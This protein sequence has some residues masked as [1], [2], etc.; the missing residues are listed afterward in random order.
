VL[1]PEIKAFIDRHAER[2]ADEIA[3][4][5]PKYPDLPIPFIAR[6]VAGRRRIKEKL[7][8]WY[9][10]PDTV[11]PAT[12][13]LEQCSSEAAACYRASLASGRTAADLTGGFGVDAKFLA[14]RFERLFYCEKEREL[15]GLADAN[16][17][18]FGLGGKVECLAM[19]GLK[20]I[21]EYEGK[22]DLV[23]LDPARRDARQ[24]KV[25][26]LSEGEPDPLAVWEKLLERA[27]RVILKAS[28]G[29]DVD[30]ALRELS[31]VEEIHVVSVEGECKELLIVAS[32]LAVGEAKIVCANVTAVGRQER[33]EFLRSEEKEMEGNYALY[34][35][36]LYEP[37]ASIMKAGAFKTFG[38]KVG[39]PLLN[40]R[41]RFYTSKEFVEDFPGRV[42]W[43]EKEGELNRKCAR[44]LFPEGKANVLA[45]N[46]GMSTAELKAKLKLKDGGE[47]FAIGC[48]DASTYRLLLRCKRLK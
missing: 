4:L 9:E 20:W 25:S 41:T 22:L 29:L 18:A 48:R 11:F 5:A 34:E 44:E 36:Y 45:R 7:P 21:S 15:A 38:A 8:S 43:V 42:F 46:A 14:E 39:L 37:N 12:L 26:K 27:E 16:F 23:Y 32:R 3:L 10:N 17:R 6:Q 35:R 47:A 19:D 1:T 31:C 28:P 40:P 24:F 13:S 2:S 30:Q 33:H